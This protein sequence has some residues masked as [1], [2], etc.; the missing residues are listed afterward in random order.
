MAGTE[1]HGADAAIPELLR[2]AAFAL[3]PVRSDAGAMVRALALVEAVGARPVILDAELHD[4]VVAATSHAPH[5]LAAAL[6][7]AS[8]SLPRDAVRDLASSGFSGATRLAASD[9]GMVAGFLVANAGAVRDALR[10][11]RASLDRAEASLNDA[12]ALRVLFT[13]AAAAREDASG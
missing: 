3:S 11:V 8:R 12:D 9:P 4:R 13:E 7:L 2:G 5:L 10:D 6:A 1:G